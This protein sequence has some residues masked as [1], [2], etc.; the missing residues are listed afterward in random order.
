[1]EF[2][3]AFAQNEDR[4][5][6]ALC[7]KTVSPKA[8]TRIAYLWAY[9][10]PNLKPP[11][12]SIT[13]PSHLP[14]GAASSVTLSPAEGST[15]KELE[16]ARE[17]RLVPASGGAAEPVAVRVAGGPGAIELDLAHSKVQPGDYRLAASWDWDTLDLGGT[18]HLHP[19]GDLGHVGLAPEFRCKL[20]EGNGKVAVHLTG[21]DFEFVEK[22]AIAKA[23]ITPAK[24]TE[25]RFVLPQG[26]RAGVQTSIAVDID[27]SS[28][29]SYS[30]LLTQSDGRSSTIPYTVLPPNP[31]LSRLPIHLNQQQ[32]G[33]PLEL[34]GTGLDRIEAVS[35]DAGEIKGSCK[36]DVWRGSITLKAGTKVGATYALALKLK[37]LDVPDTMP[38]AIKVFGPRPVITNVRKAIPGTLGVALTR[39]ELPAGTVAGLS[40]EVRQYHDRLAGDSVSRP[41]VELGWLSGGLR[42]VIK[43]APDEHVDGA[44]LTMAAPGMLFLAIDPAAV[45]YAGCVLTARVSV[46]PE[47]QSDAFPIGR[48]VR[49]PRLDQFVLTNEQLDASTYVWIL[50]GRDLDVIEKT[51]WDA[52]LG[53]P[54]DSVP[55]PV[56]GEPGLQTVRIAMPWPAPA[57]H[58]PLYVWFRGE[59]DGR[60]TSVTY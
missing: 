49:V 2:R 43:L 19:L 29:G 25:T 21:T 37:G 39:D 7:T 26:R 23:D 52:Q 47:G 22:A 35:S 10:V 58:A 3:S 28:R 30:L 50:K 20:I 44:Q 33:Q 12:V 8:R 31:V 27:T 24:L 56:S 57:P 41:Q 54:V 9:R 48:V 11:V 14:I 16:R 60:K 38:D 36:G 42:K 46:E 15:V 59:P 32:A 5:G 17:W 34:T 55:T 45:G 40:M 1:M 18:L 53:V 13:G 51:G 6:L 4:G